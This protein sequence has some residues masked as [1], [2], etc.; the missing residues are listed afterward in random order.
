MVNNIA[1]FIFQTKLGAY[2]LTVYL[3]VYFCSVFI[4]GLD[5]AWQR[6]MAQQ[7]IERLTQLSFHELGEIKTNGKS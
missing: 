5:H 7:K 6:D 4:T 2:L 1:E 3:A